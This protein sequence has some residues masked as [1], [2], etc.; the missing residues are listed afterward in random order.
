[1]IAKTCTKTE[2]KRVA[3]VTLT[4]SQ[5]LW[6]DVISLVGD[7]NDWNRALH[8]LRRDRAGKWR[9]PGDLLVGRA[10][11]FRSPLV[12]GDNQAD[13]PVH[14]AS[15]SDNFVVVTEPNKRRVRR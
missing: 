5:R 14:H 11:Q 9:L 1:M 12:M 15:N 3:R 10:Y 8:P 4:L 7:F 6:A 2:G 13:A